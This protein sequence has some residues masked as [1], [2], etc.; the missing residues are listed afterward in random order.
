M[1]ANNDHFSKE[2]AIR[3]CNKHVHN[4]SFKISDD[5]KFLHIVYAMP[6]ENKEK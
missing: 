4:M 2:K 6:E 5:K 3:E 1:M